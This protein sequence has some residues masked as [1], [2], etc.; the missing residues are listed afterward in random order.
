MGDMTGILSD[1][2]DFIHERAELF[3]FNNYLHFKKQCISI[4][5]VL[6]LCIKWPLL[7][8]LIP[9]YTKQFD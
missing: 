4:K 5:S 1:K 3:C 2:M 9:V 6:N 7:T 8:I